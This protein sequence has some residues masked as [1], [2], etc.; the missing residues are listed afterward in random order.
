MSEPKPLTERIKAEPL[1]NVN[2]KLAHYAISPELAEEIVA[3]LAA[4]DAELADIREAHRKVMAEECP[5]DEHH[6]TCVPVLRAEIKRLRGAMELAHKMA[7][8]ALPS[9]LPRED[10]VVT[11]PRKLVRAFCAYVAENNLLSKEPT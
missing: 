1:Y 7:R 10:G 4:R 2:E 8:H 3:T 6:C 11:L 5:S 9:A